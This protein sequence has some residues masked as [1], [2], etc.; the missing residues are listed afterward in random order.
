M[1][2]HITYRKDFDE[3]GNELMVEISR[4]E[5]EDI[6]SERLPEVHIEEP[7]AHKL[8]EFFGF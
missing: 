1:R 3:N 6:I 7:F 4:E 2:L 5:I 8:L